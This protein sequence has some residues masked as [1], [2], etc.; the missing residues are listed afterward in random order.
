MDANLLLLEEETAA[1]AAEED[2]LSMLSG[3]FM[4]DLVAG[5]P[6][7]RSSDDHRMNRTNS[8]HILGSERRRRDIMGPPSTATYSPIAD[9]DI[10]GR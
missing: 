3:T 10:W 8:L 9:D 2:M 1:A 4:H 7:P 5:A 6:L